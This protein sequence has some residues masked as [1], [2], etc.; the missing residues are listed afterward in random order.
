MVYAFTYYLGGIP[1][2]AQY[3]NN[4]KGALLLFSFLV[5]QKIPFKIITSKRKKK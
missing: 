2:R 4:E 5:E 1:H 3:V